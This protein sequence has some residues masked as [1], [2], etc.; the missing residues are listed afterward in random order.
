MAEPNR[1]PARR[2]IA[3]WGAGWRLFRQSPAAW[4][5]IAVI[6]FII[7]MLLALTPIVSIAAFILLPILIGGIMVGAR[8]LDRQREL[9]ELTPRRRV[10]SGR[11]RI[12]HA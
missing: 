2:G 5:G 9:S 4:I 7:E 1:L 8:E 10:A 11:P 3:S 6:A 12:A